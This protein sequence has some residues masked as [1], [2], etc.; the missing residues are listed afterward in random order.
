MGWNYET[1]FAW[2]IALYT[3]QRRFYYRMFYP[4]LFCALH[5]HRNSAFD[6]LRIAVMGIRARQIL[7]RQP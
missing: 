4:L 1:V 7:I 2:Y 3:A 5:P 6:A